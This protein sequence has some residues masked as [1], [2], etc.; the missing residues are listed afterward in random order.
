MSQQSQ[1]SSKDKLPNQN[2]GFAA[3]TVELPLL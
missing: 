2:N 1:D 3:I